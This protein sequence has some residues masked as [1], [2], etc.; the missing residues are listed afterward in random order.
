MQMVAPCGPMYQA[1]TLSGNPLTMAAGIATLEELRKPEIWNNIEYMTASLGAEMRA[2][3]KEAGIKVEVQQVGTMFMTFFTDQPV[4]DW[5]SAKR[6]DTRLYAE[7][8]RAMLS[9]GIYLAPSQFEAGFLSSFHTK[10]VVGKTIEAAHNAFQ[11][12]SE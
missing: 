1:G 11:R 5:S 4:K 7:Y 6:A 9:E 8:F 3:A 12:I 10:E 2:A